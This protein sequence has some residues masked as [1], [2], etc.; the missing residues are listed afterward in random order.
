MS[1]EKTSPRAGF[2]IKWG[3]KEIEYYGDSVKDVFTT[4]FNQ[5][6]SLPSSTTQQ[7]PPQPAISENEPLKPQP[8]VGAVGMDIYDRIAKD[9]GITIEKVI[10]VIKLEERKGFPSLVPVLPTHPNVRDAVRLVGYSIQVGEQKSPIEVSYL[11]DILKKVNGYP[12]AGSEFGLILQD[13]RR[14]DA[15]IVSK[16]QERNMPITFS[17][18]GLDD[19]RAVLQSG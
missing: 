19:A 6:R 15:I 5:V 4:V 12:L 9:A 10:E 13:F 2:R 8:L 16:T 1:D 3:D 18:K 14:A 11:K 7:T 17:K